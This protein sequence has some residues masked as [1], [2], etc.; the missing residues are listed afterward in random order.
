[1]CHLLQ[2]DFLVVQTHISALVAL[3]WIPEGLR[4]TGR[5]KEA[6][7]PGPGTQ[8]TL[9]IALL[10]PKLPLRLVLPSQSPPSR[11]SLVSE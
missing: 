1:M 5:R 6:S 9:S 10:C 7:N 11:V 3:W 8:E 2:G 4:R